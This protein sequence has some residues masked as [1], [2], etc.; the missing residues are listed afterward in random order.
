MVVSDSSGDR[1]MQVSVIQPDL[2][3]GWSKKK[4]AQCCEKDLVGG[5]V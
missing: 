1:K 2:F 3:L 5:D 4:S